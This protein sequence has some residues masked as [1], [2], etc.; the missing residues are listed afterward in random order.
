MGCTRNPLKISADAIS[1]LAL[2]FALSIPSYLWAAF[3]SQFSFLAG[4]EYN[5][6]IFFSKNKEHDFI[7]V[8]TP[9][10]TLLYAPE[11]QVAPT[12][13]AEISPS[14]QIYARN[15]D[16][17]NFDNFSAKAGY[18]YQYSPVLTLHLSDTFQR[19]GETRSQSFFGS[20]EFL[21]GPTSPPPV[22]K[23]SN[24]PLSQSLTNFISQG[25]QATNFVLL[26]SEYLYRPDI[27]FAGRYTNEFINYI[28]AGGT[29][30][31]HT[32]SARGIY[33]WRQDHN[34]HAGYKL[35]I[36]D[37]RNSDSGLIHEFDIGD[38][39]FTN[40]TLQLTP[41]LSLAA[42]SGLSIN[43]GNSGP[44]VANNTSVTITKLWE[45]AQLNGG[46]RKGLTPSYGV[47]GI[48]D[49][50]SLF[51]TFNWRLTEKL[52][53][54][55]GAQ[56]SYF[57]TDD[58]NFKTFQA[59]LGIQYLLTNWL[60]SGLNYTFNWIDVGAGANKTDL[61]QKGITKSNIVFISV[62]TRF[63]LW[64]N[65]GLAR[66]MTSSTLTPVLTPPFSV[67]PSQPSP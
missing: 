29:D 38:D 4:E 60:S 64:P 1:L 42:S 30:V 40:Y 25:K 6:N 62:T 44:R 15:S 35:S 51:T 18:S 2:L 16:L 27:S 65:I 13:R 49:T 67:R 11:G 12:L 26:E 39:Y 58:V 59:G 31:F 21:T 28:D 33:N 57:D 22:G 19:L 61:L 7:T 37:S 41:T 54:T 5:D 50:T 47:S 53:A 9:I 66:G 63:D 20:S 43:T 32:I 55:S 23:V 8:F 46:L 14:Y 24:P 45:T 36:A 34:L 56:F 52:S 10:L 17:N 3:A 48:S